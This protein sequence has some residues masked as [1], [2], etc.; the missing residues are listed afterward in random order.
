MY[1]YI[2][3]LFRTLVKSVSRNDPTKHHDRF[4]GLK[5]RFIGVQGT[6]HPEHHPG[7]RKGQTVPSLGVDGHAV[8]ETTNYR[9]TIGK[10]WKTIGKP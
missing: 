5:E 6:H 10:P 7:R 1:I 8:L 9:K 2:C 4:F 3:I